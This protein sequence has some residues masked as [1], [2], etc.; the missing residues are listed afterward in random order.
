M[1]LAAQ[2]N[3]SHHAWRCGSMARTVSSE[4]AAGTTQRRTAAL[5]T[6]TGG[7][8]RSATTTSVSG[9]PQLTVVQQHRTDPIHI[10]AGL[11]FERRRPCLVAAPSGASSVSAEPAN[12]PE[13]HF[14]VSYR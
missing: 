14:M 6:A 5:P 13:G 3:Q 12:A 7:T 8:R 10:Q 9:W 1:S 2:S 4:V 11:C